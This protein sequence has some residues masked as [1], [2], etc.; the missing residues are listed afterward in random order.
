MT[1]YQ[2]LKKLT[3]EEYKNYWEK[4]YQKREDEI[5]SPYGWLSLRSIDWLTEGNKVK[6]KGFPGEWEQQGNTVTY[7]PEKGKTVTNKNQVV[8]TPKQITVNTVA[9]VN[10]ED[11][12]YQGVRA[13]L[14][15]R[16]GSERKFA[17]RQRD[18]QSIFRKNFKGL[19]HFEP[20]VNWVLPAHY[21]PLKDW[22]NIKTKAVINELSHN[23]TQIGNLYFEYNNKE[24]RFVVFQAHNDNSGFTKKDPITGKIEYL[25]NRQNTESK[26]TIYFR[27]ATTGKKTYGGGRRL[28]INITDP[29]KLNFV[30]F[31]TAVNLPCAFSYFCTC[32]FAPVENTLPF[33]VPVGETTPDK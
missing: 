32:P 7:F 6:L 14:I 24:Y 4:W 2:N 28:R 33:E 12:D 22:K 21:V 1:N 20:D 25:D 23:E 10:V 31:N 16:L 17:V 15:K 30:D 19:P 8:D 9:D 11:F 29:E 5:K 3:T 26:G 13:Q 27:D 18:P